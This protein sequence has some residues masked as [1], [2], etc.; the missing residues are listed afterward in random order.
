MYLILQK[1]SNKHLK[2]RLSMGYADIT[3][4]IDK[5]EHTRLNEIEYKK[6]LCYQLIENS[7]QK[8]NKNGIACAMYILARINYQQGKFKQ[9]LEFLL[10]GEA[11][12]KR[13]EKYTLKIDYNTLF[14]ILYSRLGNEQQS[15]SYFLKGIKLAKLE[16]REK[17]KNSLSFYCSCISDIW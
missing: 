15:F 13:G 12:V 4:L 11:Y 10:R 6:K 8:H 14:G 2:W 17:I 5:I 16:R 7:I 1:T 3:K 9:S